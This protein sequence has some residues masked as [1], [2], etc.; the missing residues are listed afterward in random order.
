MYI[1]SEKTYFE[2]LGKKIDDEINIYDSD[3]IKSLLDY[4]EKRNIVITKRAIYYAIKNKSLIAN[5]F[6]IYKIKVK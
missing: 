1:I 4:L 2:R 3:D 6:N 5:K